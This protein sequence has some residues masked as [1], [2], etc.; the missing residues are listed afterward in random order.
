MPPSAQ[1]KPL[2]PHEQTVLAAVE[3]ELRVEDPALAAALSQIPPSSPTTPPFRLPIRPVLH[4]LAALAGLIAIVAF[5]AGR[6][7]V[8]GMAV[9]TCAA[10]VPWLIQTARSATRRSRAEARSGAQAAKIGPRPAGSTWSALPT[11]IQYGTAL[12]A[13][14]LFLVAQPLVP[15]SWRAVLGVALWLVVLP[16][17]YLW[18]FGRTE[19]R[20]TSA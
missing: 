5:T 12:L 18:F 7:S 20:D 14:V 16:A 15:P 6:L 3:E 9:V 1:E 8:L 11:G 10:V 2:S 17:G 19:R 4:L 13:V